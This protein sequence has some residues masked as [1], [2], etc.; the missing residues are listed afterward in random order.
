VAEFE[1]L[2]TALADAVAMEFPGWSL[3]FSLRTD[4]LAK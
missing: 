2:T 1:F 3:P 4:A